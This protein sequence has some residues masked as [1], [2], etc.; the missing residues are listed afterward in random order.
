MIEAKEHLTEYIHQDGSFQ[1]LPEINIVDAEMNND[2][3]CK[4]ESEE[5]SL[6]QSHRGKF[7]LWLNKI[8]SKVEE[9]VYQDISVGT[10]EY[11]SNT[12]ADDLIKYYLPS[13]SLWS[14]I[15]TGDLRRHAPKNDSSSQSQKSCVSDYYF[16]E[17][18][19]KTTGHQEQRFNT[20]KHHTLEG[21]STSRLDEFSY[22]MYKSVLSILERYAYNCI[23]KPRLGNKTVTAPVTENWEK[24]FQDKSNCEEINTGKYQKP[25]KCP[26]K[27]LKNMKSKTSATERLQSVVP[28]NVPDVIK[29]YCPI[30]NKHNLCWLT[31]SLQGL[32]TSNVIKN[33]M[34]SYVQIIDE[35]CEAKFK[36]TLLCCIF[37]HLLV[38]SP[39]ALPQRELYALFNDRERIPGRHCIP[40]TLL[41]L[42]NQ[43]DAYEFFTAGALSDVL[44][45][46][47]KVTFITY[48]LHKVK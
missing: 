35:S 3:P 20:L 44:P 19:C 7:K 21:R 12:V 37:R 33:A 41:C 18:P 17:N 42:G 14:M 47:L 4:I 24:K 40:N 9:N 1:N 29:M 26:L 28:A 15:M 48:Q 34:E 27:C 36:N 45:S 22:T 11:H 23:R 32:A 16:V 30:K 10:N 31:A 13:I 43:E 46:D 39:T 2:G 6:L 8:V 5:Q 38:K 25:P